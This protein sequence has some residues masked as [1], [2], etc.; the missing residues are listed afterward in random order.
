MKIKRR[1]VAQVHKGPWKAQK[2]LL[3]PSLYSPFLLFP[4]VVL[5]SPGI[6]SPL[7]ALYYLYSFFT[8]YSTLFLSSICLIKIFWMVCLFQVYPTKWNANTHL[9]G[10]CKTWNKQ[11]IKCMWDIEMAPLLL[12]SLKLHNREKE[13]I[14]DH[15][16]PTSLWQSNY[17]GRILYICKV[18][19]FIWLSAFPPEINLAVPDL[20]LLSCGLRE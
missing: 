18:F 16:S 3:F 11:F 17:F 1:F 20:I 13:I 12:P 7:I 9:S 4:F 10:L 19:H 8:L 6:L 14:S 2:D 15:L 5:L